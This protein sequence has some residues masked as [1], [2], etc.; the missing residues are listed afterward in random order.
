MLPAAA[1]T[2]NPKREYFLD[3]GNLCMALRLLA[4]SGVPRSIAKRPVAVSCGQGV[5]LKQP[6]PLVSPG[7]TKG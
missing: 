7:S 5:M 2:G 3:N 1:G 6:H 4:D